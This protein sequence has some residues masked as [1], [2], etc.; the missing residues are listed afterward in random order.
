LAGVVTPRYKYIL[1]RKNRNI[2][3]A[4]P[5]QKGK[6]ELYDLETDPEESHNLAAEQPELLSE[7]RELYKKMRSGKSIW[8]AQEAQIDRQTEEMLRSLGYTE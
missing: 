3:P 5:I 2:Y 1:H 6:E 7:M 8:K 4:Y